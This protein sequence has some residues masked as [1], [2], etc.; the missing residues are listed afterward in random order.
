[1]QTENTSASTIE[2]KPQKANLVLNANSIPRIVNK[3]A[4]TI[5][6]SSPV[7]EKPVSEN[8]KEGSGESDLDL[9]PGG[10]EEIERHSDHHLGPEFGVEKN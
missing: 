7:G 1:M 10:E 4:I 2:E 6:E 9:Q 3:R 8:H 5:K